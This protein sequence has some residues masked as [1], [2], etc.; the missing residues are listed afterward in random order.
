MITYI[1]SDLN[2]KKELKVYNTI[3]KSTIINSKTISII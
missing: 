3:V 1:T 2:V